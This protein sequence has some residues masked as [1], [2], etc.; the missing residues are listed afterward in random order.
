M[1]LSQRATHLKPSPTLKLA[2]TAKEMSQ[3]GLD[4]ISLSVG[5]PDWDTLKVAKDAAIQAI[6]NGFTKYTPSSGIPELRK[7]IAQVTSRQTK[8]DYSPDQVTVS[9]GG[10][11][12]IFS[13]LQT[14]LDAGDEVVIPAP[15]WVSY[16]TMVE[17]A[18][19]QPI[20]AETTEADAF[21][22][23][24][25]NLEKHINKKTKLLILNS[26]SNP[27][28][29]MYTRQ[30]LSALAAVLRK[31]SQV[32]V[33]SDD[34]YNRLVFSEDC[35][36][37]LVEVAPDLKERILV[38][39][40]AAKSF[41]MTGWRVG[42]AL[43]PA[44]WIG[45]MSN[46]QSQSVSC[47]P[48]VS[49]KATVAALLEGDPEMKTAIQLLKSR[50]DKT[51]EGLSQIPGFRPMPPDGAFYVWTQVSEHFGRSYKGKKIESSSDFSALL[52]EHK[53]VVCVPGIEFGT[54]GYLR[55]SYAIDD[56]RMAEAI[57]R[58]RSFVS[59]LS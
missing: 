9:T 27:T 20:V 36:P 35:A 25:A 45:A 57:A 4:V 43:G 2:A 55:L 49:Q 14:L 26:P 42:W 11:F 29:L 37:N 51:C 58:I 41:S 52:L 28:G 31:H 6:E 46:Y 53:Q 13:A 1:K 40:G 54:E 30:E 24:P 48:S 23:T 38:V 44:A 33:L 21:K 5:E 56:K 3:K 7:A 8:V 34:I 50:C 32:Y 22:L 10:K 19:G 18:L 12:I 16:P 39:N 47:A 17:L 59:E 15:Y